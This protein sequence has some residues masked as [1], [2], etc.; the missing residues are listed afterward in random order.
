M[1]TI[2]ESLYLRGK[3]PLPGR[4]RPFREPRIGLR[5]ALSYSQLVFTRRIIKGVEYYQA[6]TTEGGDLFVTSFGLRFAA[7]LQPDNWL[8]DQ[9]FE[10]HRQRLRG[11]SAIYRSQTK[12][13][14]GRVLD[15]VVRFNR[16]G[17]D[18]P[19][20][21]LTRDIHT[22]AAFN[23]PFEEVAEL[24]ALRAQRIGPD[25]RRIFTKRPLAIYSPPTRVELWQS[26]RSESQIAAKQARVPEVELDI[27]RPYILVYGWIDGIDVQDAAD[28]FG[29]GGA[30]RQSL[31]ADAMAEVEGELQ[32][33]G[34][35]V[36]DMKPAHIVVRFTKG[37]QLLRRKDGR[38]VYA[39]I[40]YELLERP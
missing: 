14:E 20:D 28:Q 6:K 39:L 21:T 10:A 31:L 2:M 29:M 25:R 5:T 9:W 17:Q 18:L 15:L 33:A 37:G 27:H 26:G 11:T 13:V 19:V 24:V 22:Q 1:G 23:S 36:L 38:L 34:F 8:D 3:Q 30:S 16:V 32:Q 4:G 40:D 35:R 7:H 12:R